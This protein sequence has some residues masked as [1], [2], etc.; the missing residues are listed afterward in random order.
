MPI[1]GEE[2]GEITNPTK[3]TTDV[4]GSNVLKYPEQMYSL[5]R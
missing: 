1:E 5:L 4:S 3:G 2:N